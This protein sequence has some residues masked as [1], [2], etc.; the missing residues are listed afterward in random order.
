MATEA[1]T[2]LHTEEALLLH[3]NHTEEAQLLLIHTEE[4]QL[5]LIHTEE[6]Q[7]L[8]NHTDEEQNLLHTMIHMEDRTMIHMEEAKEAKIH[9]DSVGTVR[10]EDGCLGDE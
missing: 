2:I 10:T 4:A 6:A 1:A 3:L 7:L 9:M 8:L 5:L